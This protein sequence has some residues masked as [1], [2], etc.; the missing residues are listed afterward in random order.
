M[1]ITTPRAG[2]VHGARKGYCR[3]DTEPLQ[4]FPI[5]VPLLFVLFQKEFA[6]VVLGSSDISLTFL[7]GFL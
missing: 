6:T 2:I 3:S 5:C 7:Q 4:P 1:A